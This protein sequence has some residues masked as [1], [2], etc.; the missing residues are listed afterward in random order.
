MRKF[1]QIWQKNEFRRTDFIDG[2]LVPETHDRRLTCHLCL[3]ERN[4]PAVLLTHVVQELTRLL[5]EEASDGR[6]LLLHS[7]RVLL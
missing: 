2:V 3:E 5:H 6:A 1:N 4:E 7:R